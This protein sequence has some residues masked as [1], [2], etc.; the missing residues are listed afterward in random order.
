MRS[1]GT[2]A[3]VDAPSRANYK[4]KKAAI[5]P[6]LRLHVQPHVAL[7][8]KRVFPRVDQYARE[9]IDLLLTDEAA[10]ELEWF[11]QMYPLEPIG[12]AQTILGAAARRHDSKL[13]LISETPQLLL[14]LACQNAFTS[15]ALR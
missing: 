6:H 10:S 15:K 4:D 3:V 11:M 7:R 13:Q 8:L 2:Y 1:M 9:H 5:R 12:N 14:A